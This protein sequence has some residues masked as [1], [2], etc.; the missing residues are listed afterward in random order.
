[1]KDNMMRHNRRLIERRHYVRVLI[2]SLIVAL[3]LALVLFLS[4][5]VAYAVGHSTSFS[6]EVTTLF[7]PLAGNSLYGYFL[8]GL[9]LALLAV[10][11]SA[12]YFVQHK[13]AAHVDDRRK[14]CFIEVNDES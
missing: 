11:G 8:M 13:R 14:D 5:V 2:A 12:V 9:V 6:L 10:V 3:I 1:M 7:S 4:P